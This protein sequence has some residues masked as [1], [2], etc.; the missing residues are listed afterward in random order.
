M[1]HI[2]IRKTERDLRERAR[3]AGRPNLDGYARGMEEAEHFAR[4]QGI[5]NPNRKGW[6]TDDGGHAEKQLR[7][8]TLRAMGK[9]PSAYD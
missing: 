6:L 2:I 9:D 1:T 7:D 5:D 4:R 3:E 8:R